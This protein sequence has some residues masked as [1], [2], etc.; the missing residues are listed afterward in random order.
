[1]KILI[2]LILFF[3]LHTSENIPINKT[4]D[5]CIQETVE[6]TLILLETET[7]H[8]PVSM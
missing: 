4:K 6:F 2:S 7:I 3:A 5:N 1:M 8:D